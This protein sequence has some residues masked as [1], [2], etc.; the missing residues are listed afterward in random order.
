MSEPGVASPIDATA[1]PN[2]GNPVTPEA[3]FCPSCGQSLRHVSD[4]RRIVTVLFADLVGFTALAETHDPE[5]VKNLV[6]NCFEG[7][8]ADVAA[9]GGRVDKI[10]GDAIVA[11]FGAPIAHEDDAER[12]VRAGL[13]MQRTLA[14]WAELEAAH[15]LKMRVGI[16]TGEVLVGALRAGGDYTAMGDVVNIASR[17][18]YT[19]EPGQVVVG[20]STYQATRRI[21][22]YT[23]LGEVEAKGR[24]E[25][26]RAW[27]AERAVLPPGAR[28][29]R[30]RS[31]LVGRERELALM[32]QAIDATVT[33]DRAHLLLIIA[34]AGMGKTRL[35]EEVAARSVRTHDAVVLEGRCVPYG[36]AN[37]W[38]PVAEAVRHGCGISQADALPVAQA[39]A[40]ERV[41]Q[42]LGETASDDDIT[43][44]TNGLLHLLGYDGPLAAI[45]ATRAREEVTRSVLNFLEGWSRRQA[46]VIVLSDLHWADDV[47]LELGDTLFDRVAGR[48]VVLIATARSTLFDRWQPR[49]GRHNMVVL[50]LDPLDRESSSELLDALGGREFP[51]GLRQAL[52]DRS[53][54]NPFF[55][56]ELVSLVA[57]AKPTHGVE[58]TSPTLTELPDTLRG[59]VAARLDGLTTDERRVLADAAVLGRRGELVGLQVMGDQAGAPEIAAA[60]DGLVAKDLLLVDRGRWSFRSDLVREVAYSMLTKADRARRHA[61][62]ASWMEDT[63]PD[64]PATDRIAHHYATAARLAAEIGASAGVAPGWADE[65]SSRALC[66]LEKALDRAEEAE[67]DPVALRVASK[68]LELGDTADYQQRLRFLLARAKATTNMRQLE[69]ARADIGAALELTEAAGDE[70][71]RALALVHRGDL[72]QKAADL[73]ASMATLST[74]IEVFRGLDDRR[75]TAEALRALGMTKMFSGDESGSEAAFREA[76]AICEELGDRRGEAWALQNLAWLAFTNGRGDEAEGWLASSIEMFRQIGDAGG[77]GWALGLLAWVRYWAGRLTEAEALGEQILA[78]A[79]QRGDKWAAAMMQV[80][81]AQVRLWTGQAAGALDLAESAVG[82]FQELQDWYGALQALGALGRIRLA[83]GR[84]EDGFAALVEGIDVAE[85]GTSAQARQVAGLHLLVGA[86]HAGEPSRV[87]PDLPPPDG[88]ADQTYASPDLAGSKLGIAQRERVVAHALLALQRGDALEAGDELEPMVEALGIESP[89][90]AAVMALVRTATGDVVGARRAVAAVHEAPTATYADRMLALVADGL[91]AAGRGEVAAARSTLGEA[92]QIVDAT[93]DRLAQALV[94][95]AEARAA[96]RLGGSSAAVGEA[97]AGLADFGLTDLGWDTAF[98]A[99]LAGAAE[100]ITEL[101]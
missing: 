47:I 23:A 83:L 82:T 43:R 15:H 72:E 99:A 98:Q 46:V 40:T 2:C 54:G 92:R 45:E 59:L 96:E 31:P 61:A 89:A 58:I 16:N 14:D 20:P 29:G 10:V 17:L 36:E 75:H 76:L 39:K 69:R 73:D 12:A 26:V 50:N 28:P 74:A 93:E 19:A 38:W 32:G 5:Q 95:L 55:L 67:L 52:V 60:L 68:A 86:G 37:V 51:S 77:L 6:D 42:A 71:G 88:A 53:G 79:Q 18:Q 27:I 64:R 70:R 91:G 1:C 97:R 48:R 22:R 25:L 3:R 4:E 30:G 9:Y 33:R 8:V 87:P 11:L 13:Q 49:P 56:E 85:K 34:E 44:V 101:A 66:W 35:A 41:E 24:G 63:A 80:L 84:I 62:V 94:R 100:P 81:V 57:E 7:L 90:L 65:L 78:E 21:V